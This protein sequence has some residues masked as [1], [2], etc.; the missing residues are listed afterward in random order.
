M[1]K[2]NLSNI[3]KKAWR[4]KKTSDKT[5]SECLKISWKMAKKRQRKLEAA[6]E[7]Y[8]LIEKA[9]KV[10]IKRTY[11]YSFFKK[12]IELGLCDGVNLKKGT[13]H[14]DT[15]EID[16]E[17]TFDDNFMCYNYSEIREY[18]IKALKNFLKNQN[19]IC[20]YNESIEKYAKKDYNYFCMSQKYYNNR[21]W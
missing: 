17:F 8:A 18:N 21:I 6:A 1:K 7:G 3:M 13:Y 9:K 12:E 19:N 4:L 10:T 5:F 15:K 20:F 2:Y 11:K 16:L 14:S